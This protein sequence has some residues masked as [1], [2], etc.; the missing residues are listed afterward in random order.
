MLG[1]VLP[2][3]VL[4]RAR[5]LRRSVAATIIEGKVVVPEDVATRSSI[6]YVA[7]LYSQLEWEIVD[8]VHQLQA[9]DRSSRAVPNDVDLE[10]RGVVSRE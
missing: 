1:G 2:A 7:R 3:G 9:E 4:V 8:P 10:M 5:A 6:L